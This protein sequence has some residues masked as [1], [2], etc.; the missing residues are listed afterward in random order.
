MKSKKN[1]KLGGFCGLNTGTV[2]N[3]FSVSD[4]SN[5]KNIG[6]FCYKNTG[7][8]STCFAMP[9]VNKNHNADFCFENCGQIINS[10]SNK[11]SNNT[12][13]STTK[14]FNNNINYCDFCNTTVNDLIENLDLTLNDFWHKTQ[15]SDNLLSLELKNSCYNCSEDEKILDLEPVHIRTKE[16]LIFISEK[17]KNGDGQSAGAYYVLEND[18]DLKNVN[19]E[20]IGNI[21]CPFTGV[22]DGCGHKIYN[23]KVVSKDIMFAGFFGVVEHALIANLQ[24]DGMIKTGSCSGGFAG[25]SRESRIYSCSAVS[26]VI[27]TD[28]VGGFI[29]NNTGIIEGCYFN[30]KIKRPFPL[31]LLYFLPVLIMM[32]LMCIYILNPMKN[33]ATFNNVPIDPYTV[34]NNKFQTYTGGQNKASF[35]FSDVVKFVN[36]TATVKFGSP[37][38]ANQSMTIKIQITDQEL[39]EKL[40]KT[41][42]TSSEQKSLDSNPKYDPSNTRVTVSES[43][44][45]LPGYELK[46]LVLDKLPD[47]TYLPKGVYRGIA[48]LNFFNGETNEKAMI[49]TQI[50]ITVVVE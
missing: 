15:C 16:D 37:D 38:S 43:G 25:I 27:G 28:N 47:G 11:K 8:I 40:G 36:N 2:L 6:S 45:V 14:T 10:F 49:N 7:E 20:P 32:I 12:V 30:G 46:K 9:R 24:V 13:S 17:I 22:F 29:G 39:K 34:K 1:I 48:F 5:A 23:F 41:G 44:L 26:H 4:M 21:I 33:T 3:S 18:I 19:W 35:S 50:P 42:R 31:I